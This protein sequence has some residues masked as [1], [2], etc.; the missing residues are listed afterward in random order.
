[1]SEQGQTPQNIEAEQAALGGI[2]IDPAWLIRVR[3]ELELEG[4][5]FYVKRHEWIYE[6]MLELHESRQAIDFLSLSDNLALKQG[7]R[8]DETRL[9]SIGG[10]AYLT[11]LMNCVPSSINTR[12]YG[13]IV[14]SCSILRQYIETCGKIVRLAH[15]AGHSHESVVLLQEQI[16]ES[17]L[18]ISPAV[19]RAGLKRLSESSALFLDKLETLYQNRQ[20]GLIIGLPTGLIDVDRLFGGF[21]DGD[22]YTLAARP[23]MGKSA[24]A[25]DF[26]WHWS[27]VLRRPGV[28]FSI[29]MGDEQLV[30]RLITK[31][32]GI[33]VKRLRVGDIRDGEWQKLLN[34]L[35]LIAETPIIIDDTAEPTIQ[36]IRAESRRLAL[37]SGIE[38][39][40][41]D[42]LQLI[43]AVGKYGNREQEVAS[44]S[45]SVKGMA[46]E[47][48]LPVLSLAQL[49]RAVEGR[50]DKRP[51][52]SDLRE[53]GAVEQ[54]S[55]AVMFLYRE[56]YYKKDS[57]FPNLTELIVA[58]YRHDKTGVVNLFFNGEFMRFDSMVSKND[59]G[60]GYKPLSQPKGGRGH[61][62]RDVKN[63]AEQ[64]YTTTEFDLNVES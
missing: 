32:T 4:A 48:K 34:A 54:D 7:D 61:T 47:L 51:I 2:I 29:E 15:E 53:S 11:S 46:R 23:G 39:I 62:A 44:I 13:E 27:H 9:D 26:A 49:S 50:G 36:H 18:K 56:G 1:M 16:E 21:Q 37:E 28:I 59:R 3:D 45:R 30:Q 52:L 64:I 42:Y 25:L 57:E 55:D 63:V 22:V 35:K 58:K 17:I 41:L 43:R 8:P 6:A 38:Y 19:R 40:I 24:M 10:A 14:K 20:D 33:P 60:D 31:L 12:T 5:D